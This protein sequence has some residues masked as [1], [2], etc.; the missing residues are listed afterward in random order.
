MAL[1]R[2][3]R[4]TSKNATKIGGN[5][6]IVQANSANDSIYIENDTI[7]G[8]LVATS[9]NSGASNSVQIYNDSI[10]GSVTI[11]QGALR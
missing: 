5:V 1:I 8:K 9:Q 3:R 11:N 2:G 10:N 4:F 7:N 6:S